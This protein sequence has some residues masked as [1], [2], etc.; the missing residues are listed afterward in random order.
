[1]FI[2]IEDHFEFHKSILDPIIT[3]SLFHQDA[4][5][6]NK[7]QAL[8]ALVRSKSYYIHR[9]LSK[10]SPTTEAPLLIQDTQCK[11]FNQ[12]LSNVKVVAQPAGGLAI[13]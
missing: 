3:T 8:S 4:R 7:N 10:L 1:M 9:L 2:H 13:R 11:Y 12:T 6:K 5:A